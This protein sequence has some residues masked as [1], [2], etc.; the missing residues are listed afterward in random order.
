MG[1]SQLA[2]E[3]LS[4]TR[5]DLVIHWDYDLPTNIDNADLVI[6]TSWSGNTEETISSYQAALARKFDVIVIAGGGKLVEL[7]RENNTPLVILPE[8]HIP[9]RTAT[10][11]MTGAL[12]ALLGVADQL[13]ISLDATI[14]EEEGKALAEKIGPKVPLIYSAYPLR[15]LTGFWKMAFNE[16]A[17][18]PAYANWFPSAAH[19]ELASLPGA[20][21]DR[22]FPIII[23]DTQEDPRHARNLDALLALLDKREYTDS[24]VRLSAGGTPLEKV[25]NNYILALWTSFYVATKNGV[26]PADTSLI[27]EFKEL[28][29]SF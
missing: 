20:S 2:A 14:S 3:I 5:S 24:I 23:R 11:Y 16:N 1:G 9:P 21:P 6:C 22:Y 7:A 25:F 28:K 18:T 8:D 26:D 15:R 4:M 27:E 19:Y 17:K 10:G 13:P 12:F 29:K